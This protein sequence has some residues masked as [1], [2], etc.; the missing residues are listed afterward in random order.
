MQLR[1]TSH[2]TGQSQ[3]RRAARIH[4]GRNRGAHLAGAGH[5]SASR[6]RGRRA[7]R[8]HRGAGTRDHVPR[9]LGGRRRQGPGEPRLPRAVQQLPGALQGGPAPASVRGPGHHQVPRLRADL[10]EQP[11]H[12]AHGR[13]QGRLRLRPEGQVGHGGHALLPELH[14]RALH[15]TSA[16]TPT[17]RPATSARARA[18]SATCSASTSAS[19]T[20]GKACSRARACPTAARWPARRRRA[21]AWSTSCRST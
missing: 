4:P 6:I 19:R 10:Q 13:R 14:D 7:P 5:R 15:A 3:E 9:A 16:P 2:R 8:A 18:R 11:D 20:S 21:T 17:C 12:A 1:R